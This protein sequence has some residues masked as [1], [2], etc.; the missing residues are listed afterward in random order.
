MRRLGREDSGSPH[1]PLRQSVKQLGFPA[2]PR[3]NYSEDEAGNDTSPLINNSSR[4]RA[5]GER[6]RRVLADQGA[7][8]FGVR[9]WGRGGGG[10]QAPS[11]PER[12]TRS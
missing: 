10:A 1:P 6:E 4:L 3:S 8:G 11:E 5:G 7:P 12:G 9:V 2:S